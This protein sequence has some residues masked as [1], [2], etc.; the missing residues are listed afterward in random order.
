MKKT[1]FTLL[2][3]LIFGFTQGQINWSE[4]LE[5]ASSSYGNNRPRT[6]SDQTGNPIVIWGN[7]GNVMLSKW[8]GASF[9]TPTQIN[10]PNVTVAEA[11]WMGPEIASYGDTIYVVYKQTPEN[12]TTSGIY[13]IRSIDGANSFQTPVRVDNI[14]NN[15]SRFSTVHVGANGDVF[16]GFMMFDTNFMDPHWVVSKSTDGGLT[17]SSEIKASG[18]ENTP[19]EACDCCPGAIT[20]EGNKVAMLY[21]NNATNIRDSWASISSNGGNNFDF[22]MNIDQQNW[23][24]DY[25]PSSGPSGFIINNT[26]YSVFMNGASGKSL[27]Y[28][29]TVD[30]SDSTCNSSTE[31]N[32][33]FSNLTQQNYPRI[34]NLKNR[35]LI[36]WKQIVFGKAQLQMMYTDSIQLGFIT[37]P[38]TVATNYVHS[39]DALITDN[40]LFIVWQDYLS[41]SV[42][43]RFGNFG[44]NTSIQSKTLK[45]NINVSPNPSNNYWNIQGLNNYK[46][47]NLT[48]LNRQHQSLQINILHQQDEFITIDNKNL[49]SGIYFLHINNDQQNQMLKLIKQ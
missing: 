14:G 3:C 34:T 4:K 30:L 6:V 36:V 46:N 17:F 37:S 12:D 27:V 39:G 40:Q 49:P 38:F 1:I 11:T 15:L 43:Y 13:C 16:I 7:D 19:S 44:I 22:S 47:T 10:P 23:F 18:L 2:A 32:T 42:K 9:S 28:Y 8:N 21:R 35:A 45:H 20:S 25:C 48:L 29:N 24:I 31:L 26:L 41:N 33:N 5:L